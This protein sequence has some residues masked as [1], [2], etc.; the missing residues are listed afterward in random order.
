MNLKYY[1]PSRTHFLCINCSKKFDL[2]RNRDKCPHCGK[3]YPYYT[4][5]EWDEAQYE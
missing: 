2:T 1:D 4:K 3:S 5:E